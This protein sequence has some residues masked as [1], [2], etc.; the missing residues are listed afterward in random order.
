MIREREYALA[1]ECW[2]KKK[3]IILPN[4]SHEFPSTQVKKEMQTNPVPLLEAI[5]P[6]ILMI[7]MIFYL[8]TSVKWLELNTTAFTTS[9]LKIK[10]NVCSLQCNKHKEQFRVIYQ[11]KNYK[12]FAVIPTNRY[13]FLIHPHLVRIGGTTANSMSVLSPQDRK[14]TKISISWRKSL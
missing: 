2:Q 13:A 5:C 8:T 9:Q 3:K 1:T 14:H 11:I 7:T 6:E 12:D 4:R 10:M